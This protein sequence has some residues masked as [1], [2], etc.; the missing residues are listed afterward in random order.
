MSRMDTGRYEFNVVKRRE[1]QVIAEGRRDWCLRLVKFPGAIRPRIE[2]DP[3]FLAEGDGADLTV[4]IVPRL[5]EKALR[6]LGEEF[7][8][9]SVG[10][11]DDS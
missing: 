8:R 1:V 10:E 5:L 2:I 11:G 3:D 7:G 6:I 4:P 9:R